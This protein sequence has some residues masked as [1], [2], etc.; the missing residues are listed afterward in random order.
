ME[1]VINSLLNQIDVVF[2]ISYNLLDIKCNFL[3][4]DKFI[5]LRETKEGG[6]K[7]LELFTYQFLVGIFLI[8]ST[9]GGILF[10]HKFIFIIF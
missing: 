2:G 4:N 3:R 10:V 8:F 5:V 9:I 7:S 6:E 1:G